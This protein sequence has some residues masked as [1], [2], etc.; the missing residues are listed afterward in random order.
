MLVLMHAPTIEIVGI[1]TVFGNAP[2][3]VVDRTTRDLVGRI[4][5]SSSRLVHS[6]SSTALVAEGTTSIKP[7]HAALER[8]LEHGPL[9]IVSLGR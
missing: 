4:A 9:T 7:A 6:G 3:P 1:S 2:L 8:A 5:G